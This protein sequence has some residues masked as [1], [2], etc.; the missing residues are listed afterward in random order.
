[1]KFGLKKKSTGV[2]IQVTDATETA[3][4]RQQAVAMNEALIVS[5]TQ[6]HELAEV[7]GSLS[8]RLRAA[9][10]TRDHFLAVLSHELRNP[11]AAIRNAVTL[12]VRSGTRTFVTWLRSRSTRS[13]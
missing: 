11:L 6:Q 13:W 5:S 9:V 8:A 10:E 2:M 12:A 3:L 1:M 4:F 7:A